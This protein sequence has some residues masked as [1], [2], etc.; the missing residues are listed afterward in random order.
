MKISKILST[1]GSNSKV[2]SDLRYEWEDDY[3]KAL[4]V[5][6]TT[7]GPIRE[8]IRYFSGSIMTKLGMDSVMQFFDKLTV[9]K[10]KTLVFTLYPFSKY[11]AKTS[12]NVIPF[13]ID[14]DFKVDLPTFYR[15]YK[16]CECVIISSSL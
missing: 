14:F 8:K 2:Y 15:T 16:N 13:I 12:A 11:N 7:Y 3:S 5:P 4:N 9:S 1:R 10:E 6:I